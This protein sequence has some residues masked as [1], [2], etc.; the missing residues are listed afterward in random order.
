MAF[1]VGKNGAAPPAWAALAL[2]V[3]VSVGGMALY[4]REGASGP[5]HAIQ[6]AFSVIAT[7]LSYAG[8]GVGAGIDGIQ[9]AVGDATADATTLSELREQNEELRALVS[10][11]VEYRQEVDR[12]QA[13]LNMTETSDIQGV[14]ASVVGRSADAWNQTVTI[15]VGSAAGVQAGM[16]VMGSSGVVGQ[17]VEVAP[18]SSTVRLLTDPQSG[19]AVFVQSSRAEGIVRGSLE[20]VLYLED[21]DTSAQVAVGDVVVTSGLGGSYVSGLVVG[22]V[23][24]VEGGQ[25]SATRTIVVAPN[26]SAEPLQ[27]VVV[28]FSVGATEGGDAA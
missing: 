18:S 14:G 26:D 2:C 12:L 6:G 8:A 27:E 24:S 13:R 3:V 1:K 22:T 10:Q 21:V 4:A 19:A 5:L 17:V 23:V 20:G 7:P 11:A 16:T 15:N 9:T 25:T 28:V